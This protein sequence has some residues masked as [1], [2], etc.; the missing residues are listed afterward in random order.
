MHAFF[1]SLQTG[2]SKGWESLHRWAK[3]HQALG[4]VCALA[5]F[6]IAV[7]T[8][9]HAFGLDDIG[10]AAFNLI[11]TILAMVVQFL[12]NIFTYIVDIFLGFARYNGFADA[13]PVRLGWVI[14]RDI[15]N[16]FF[17]VILLISA[18]STIIPWDASLRYNAVV[19][20]LLLMAI[21]INFSRTLI[22]VLIDLSQVVM[23]TFVNAFRAAGAGN[24]VAA[25]KIDK[26]LSMQD[27]LNDP[28]AAATAA[29]ASNI[30]ELTKI[31]ASF[32]LALILVVIANGV[33]IIMTAY[34]LARIIGLW[35]I[36][37]F[38]PAA[39]FMTALPSRLQVS[40]F[41][42]KYWSRLGG[43]L[44]GGPV[45]MFF[46]YLTFAILQDPG[47]APAAAPAPPPVAGQPA[48]AAPAAPVSSG[49]SAQVGYQQTAELHGSQATGFLT[50]VGTSDE[51]A[52]F[53]VAVAL[54]LMA[55]E[56]AME[57]ANAVDSSLGKFAGS[58]GSGSKALAFGAAT[59]AAS[60]PWLA[61]KMGYRG[62]DS[63]LDITGKASKLGMATVGHIP[64][65]GRFAH[66]MLTAG[67]T[68]H[69]RDTKR[70]ADERA[71][72]MVDATPDQARLIASARRSRVGEAMGGVAD[73][74]VNMA[75][76]GS[77]L[78]RVL[79]GA[80]NFAG[81]LA[82]SSGDR[83]TQMNDAAHL[84]SDAVVTKDRQNLERALAP[85]VRDEVRINDVERRKTDKN[86]TRTEEGDIEKMIVD[87]AAREA[88]QSQAQQLNMEQAQA[89]RIHDDVALKQI[90]DA[91]TKNPMLW[92]DSAKR[93]EKMGD[94]GLNTE[95][96]KKIDAP[97]LLNGEVLMNMM[98]KQGVLTE[99]KKGNVSVSKDTF[100]QETLLNN[101]GGASKEARQAAEA[102][103]VQIQ[104]TTIN[105]KEDGMPGSSKAAL[106]QGRMEKD[107]QSGQFRFVN[108]EANGGANQRVIRNTMEQVSLD[109]ILNAL[110]PG[111]S[112][113]ELGSHAQKYF[114]ANGSF[115]A[116][117]KLST[118]QIEKIST[119]LGKSFATLASSTYDHN[120][121]GNMTVNSGQEGSHRDLSKS[122][123][124]LFNQIPTMSQEA[125]EKM[126]INVLG[127][128]AGFSA[129]D[130]PLMAVFTS[131]ATAP[132]GN[133]SFNASNA[134][135]TIEEG[136]RPKLM[137]DHLEKLRA[138]AR[139][140]NKEVL[141]AISA[142]FKRAAGQNY[143]EEV[144]RTV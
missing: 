37:I 97:V 135:L 57:A 93:A 8:S 79:R 139:S 25:F 17:I 46:I 99:D 12:A 142:G 92:T 45:V 138:A 106:T 15:C 111:A 16:M 67:M 50:R 1:R 109:K 47:T 64:L 89:E 71:K 32:L 53:I 66:P 105:G 31:F 36:L 112:D 30:D 33:M 40:S 60:S 24:F 107:K 100:A 96:M 136:R 128:N 14:V 18:F 29:N 75:P 27:D 6:L 121:T 110:K 62:L 95:A 51:V 2:I 87:R 56:A 65:V 39:F 130:Q 21:L 10:M 20:K 117:S 122:L 125:R 124:A 134:A 11:V 118:D 113:T 61:A 91:R 140:S 35:I 63:R 88:T 73:K 41:A 82:Y 7:P 84:A 34:V 137:Q 9:A 126:V 120:G 28:T 78:Q 143:D 103:I 70:V 80:T 74:V 133:A 48:P 102:M 55:I 108:T 58:I 68:K 43:L 69:A 38:S 54:M 13:L 42:S 131:T 144:P 86:F 101:L 77:S 4:V 5:L 98:I 85:G 59:M 3:E 94:A 52:S 141:A 114:A 116:F 119:A 76:A 90:A 123:Q 23:L 72:L 49:L 81:D 127:A 115:D 26:L 104:N 22:Q 19:P 44:T 132:K 129:G 83:Q